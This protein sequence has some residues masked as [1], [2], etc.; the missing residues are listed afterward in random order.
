MKSTHQSYS[1]LNGVTA[2]QLY[3]KTFYLIQV[4]PKPLI[5]NIVSTYSTA[6]MI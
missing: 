6:E 2:L 1:F 3:L 4:S 5:V